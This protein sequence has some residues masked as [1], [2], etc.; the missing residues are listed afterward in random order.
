[1]KKI[2]FALLGIG[3]WTACGGSD[4]PSNPEPQIE[5]P[6]FVS[7]TPANGATEVPDGQLTVELLFDQNVTTP[8]DRQSKVTVSEGATLQNSQLRGSEESKIEC[9]RR[10]FKAI[11]GG[12]Y[13]YDVAT[14]YKSLYDLV[15]K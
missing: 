6:R 12:G 15:T 2:L 13:I 5:A 7:S 3:L 8:A 9:A 10:H 11:S 14:D 4:D 1:M